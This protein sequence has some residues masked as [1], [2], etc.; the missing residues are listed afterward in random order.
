MTET[1]E[2]SSQVTELRNDG[3]SFRN[4]VA[5]DDTPSVCDTRRTTNAC[6]FSRSG[7]LPQRNALQLLLQLATARCSCKQE[8]RV[9]VCVTTHAQDGAVPANACGDP[10]GMRGRPAETSRLH[11][12]GHRL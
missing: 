3:M 11:S 5:C 7:A 1:D 9:H 4:S 12:H 8:E 2:V 10:G 6:N